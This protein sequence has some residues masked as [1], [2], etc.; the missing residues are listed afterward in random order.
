MAKYART[1]KKK[2]DSGRA[3]LESNLEPCLKV[4]DPAVEGL[5]YK[6]TW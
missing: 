4:S 3:I 5:Q 6:D 2:E 1:L